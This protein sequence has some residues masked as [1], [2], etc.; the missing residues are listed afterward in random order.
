MVKAPVTNPADHEIQQFAEPAVRVSVMEISSP[1]SSLFGSASPETFFGRGDGEA[2]IAAAQS[3]S[4]GTDPAS[5]KAI[6]TAHRREINRI[7]GYKLELTRAEEKKLTE[8]KEDILEIAGKAL[9]GTARPDELDD[10]LEMLKEAN[11]IIGKP[12]VDVEAD[13]KL[14]EL[15]ALKVAILEPKLDNATAKRVAFLERFRDSIEQ[16]VIRSPDRKSLKNKFNAIVQQIDTMKPL[17]QTSRLSKAERR[18]Y[19]DV[20][21]LINDHIGAKVELTTRES[22]RVAS[23]EASIVQFQ[24]FV[25]ADLSQQPTPQAVARAYT[26]LSFS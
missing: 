15:N 9:E 5:A 18:T 3:G 4:A 26:S 20:V 2:V 17:R 25:G 22:D 7:R 10:R 8:L 23:L 14:A 24:A 19:D 1:V 12:I 11:R 16:Q 6:V 13:D 21:E